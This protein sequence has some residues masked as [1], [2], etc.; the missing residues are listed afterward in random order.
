LRRQLQALE[1]RFLEEGGFTERLY[2]ARKNRR[3]K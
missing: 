3:K 1:Q 2:Q